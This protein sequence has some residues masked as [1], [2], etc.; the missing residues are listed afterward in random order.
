MDE[1]KYGYVLQP[2]LNSDF[3]PGITPAQSTS[4]SNV[5]IDNARVNE[6]PFKIEPFVDTVTNAP[7]PTGS[8]YVL[9]TDNKVRTE[10]PS[11]VNSLFWIGVLF[12]LSIMFVASVR[13]R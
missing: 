10:V 2:K 9:A 12:T 4:K 6:S 13:H 3:I 1:V 7:V 8:V 11:D 5:T